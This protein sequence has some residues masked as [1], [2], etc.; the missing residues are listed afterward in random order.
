MGNG[1]LIQRLLA[2][3]IAFPE[4]Q[5]VEIHL[6]SELTVTSHALVQL[7]TVTGAIAHS[8]RRAA[9]GTFFCSYRTV[10]RPFQMAAKI[11]AIGLQRN[12]HPAK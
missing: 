8:D 6:T 3:H 4:C 1:K 10:L 7:H 2:L 5:F 11:V 9:L 12:S